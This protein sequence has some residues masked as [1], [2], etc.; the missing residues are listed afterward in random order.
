[1]ISFLDSSNWFAFG[2]GSEMNSAELA[3]PSKNQVLLSRRAAIGHDLPNKVKNQDFQVTESFSNET[4]SFVVFTRPKVASSAQGVERKLISGETPLIWAVGLVENGNIGFHTD[5]NIAA[6]NLFSPKSAFNGQL[7][8]PPMDN[9]SEERN[10]KRF[11]LMK[12]HGW[13]LFVAW[14][15]LAPLGIGVA[16]YSKDYIPERWFNIHVSVLFGGSFIL[17][18]VGFILVFIAVDVGGYTHLDYTNFDFSG[19]VH[20]LLGIGIVV[21]TFLQVISG[22]V[23][24]KLF[25][26]NRTEIPWWDKAHHWVGRLLV[27]GSVINIPLGILLFDLVSHSI[28][29][30]WLALYGG[31]IFSVLVTFGFLQ[32]KI[33]G[34]E[35][36]KLETSESQ[37]SLVESY[38]TFH[39]NEE[40]R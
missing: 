27:T 36:K 18:I 34:T 2:L 25:D 1:M 21:L 6:A 39:E 29:S 3:Q 13:V 4:Y 7:P 15:I 20:I 11:L 37:E 26:A 9:S 17:T 10:N 35:H 5:F 22:F 12:I 33:G 19:G 23:I 30:V 31:F 38:G 14:G 40:T 16:R 8:P 32:Y 24:D 28:N